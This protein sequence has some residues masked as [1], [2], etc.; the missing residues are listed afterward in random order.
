M[1]FARLAPK[2]ALPDGATC[3]QQVKA[4][5]EY[6]PQ[7]SV[8][9]H[10]IPTPEP[11]T[12]LD[13]ADDANDWSRQRNYNERID[14]NYAGTTDEIIQWVAC[15]WGLDE[16]DLRAKAAVESSWRQSL[17]NADGEY[18]VGLMQVNQN[19]H[20]CLPACIESTAYN[21]DWAAAWQR[22]CV[23]GDFD[24]LG[25]D[26]LSTVANYN[27]GSNATR[28]HEGCL[29]VWY[30]GDWYTGS[31]GTGN[32]YAEYLAEWRDARSSRVWLG[33]R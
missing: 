31:G 33:Y 27:S 28:L 5:P 14:G 7:N 9:N 25:S 23:D 3:A 21:A 4:R 10:T 16:D 18:S 29:A 26:Y 2:A 32:T 30:A 1:Y 20:H 6:R 13:G 11:S 22:A 24:W 12:V 8:A 17:I 15:K 19:Y